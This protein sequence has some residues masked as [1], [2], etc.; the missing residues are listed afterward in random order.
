MI[1]LG[2]D[3]SQTTGWALYDP[4]IR[5]LSSMRCG[6]IRSHSGPTLEYRAAS[7]G[8]QLV[9]LVELE[10]PDFAVIEQPPRTQYQGKKAKF[11]GEDMEGE[12]GVTGLQSFA[13]T[14]QVA[15]A[16]AT[17]LAISHVPFEVMD[18]KSWR[19]HAYGFGSRPTWARS[20]WK[21]HARQLCTISKIKATNDDMAEACWIALA[22]MNCQ[23]FKVIRSKLEAA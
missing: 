13:S 7:I 17:I 5:T 21:R 8:Q 1:I 22:G 14:N 10:K 6:T 16:L 11:F 18:V 4:S 19:T 20:E 23:T 15:A 2:L 9:K 12:V 3:P